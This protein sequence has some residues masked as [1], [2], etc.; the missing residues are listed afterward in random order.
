MKLNLKTIIIIAV[1]IIILVVIFSFTAAKNSEDTVKKGEVDKMFNIWMGIAGPG[2]KV[3]LTQN[4]PAIKKDIYDKLATEEVIKLKNY[5][6]ALQDMLNSKST[7]LSATFLNSLAYLTSNF[8]TAKEIVGKTNASNVFA[9]FGFGSVPAAKDAESNFRTMV[10]S[11]KAYGIGDK[12]CLANAIINYTDFRIQAALE[13]VLDYND[14]KFVQKP[15]ASG[16]AMAIVP[17][18]IQDDNLRLSFKSC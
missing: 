5:S 10:A 8:R 13:T 7:P 11:T 6:V 18:Y 16:I 3:T 2:D 15:G 4:A 17:H 1:V 14:R 9:N 12:T